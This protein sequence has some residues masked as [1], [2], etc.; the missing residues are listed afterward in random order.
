[1]DKSPILIGSI[2][3]TRLGEVWVAL[4]GH[5]LVTVEFGISRKNFEAAVRKQT[6]RDVEYKVR[7]NESKSLAVA[8]HQI[9]EY[10]DGKRR[11]FDIKIDWSIL[12]S[13]FQRAALQVVFSI[14]YGQTRT[15]AQVAA[16][17]GHPD[18]PRAVGRAN[19]TNPMPL[20]IPCH[21]VIGTDGKLHG[22]GGAGGLKTKAWL[23]KMEG[24]KY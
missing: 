3:T 14:P 17:I 21:R 7:V 9:K 24:A 5:G 12:T 1:M 6:H 19:A 18:A 22:Y 15:Y 8:S 4:S 11:A 2:R 20:V 16:E 23:L 10:L 13:D